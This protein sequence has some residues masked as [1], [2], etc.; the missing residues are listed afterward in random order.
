M[1]LSLE[2]CFQQERNLNMAFGQH[3]SFYLRD[4]WIERIFKNVSN[5][6]RFF[7]RKDAFEKVGLGKNMVKSLRFWALATNLVDERIREDRKKGHFITDFSK[8]VRDNDPYIQ[9]RDTLSLL[10]YYIVSRTEP[11][12]TWYWFFNIYNETFTTKNRISED[13]IEWVDIEKDIKVS[14][15]SL[16]RDVDCLIKLYTAG[17]NSQDPEEVNQSPLHVLNL[18]EVSQNSVRKVFKEGKDIGYTTLMYV[19]LDYAQTNQTKDL[20]V[21]EILNQPG[22]WGRVFN[23]SRSSVVDS[24]NRLTDHPKHSI[25]FIRTNNLDTVRL[26]DITPLEFLQFEYERKAEVAL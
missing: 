7:Y 3:Q 15:N 9:M 23:M 8:F 2:L 17:Q 25:S 19:L 5:D 24:L 22:L 10:H 1:I 16:K 12:T 26:P 18:L 21:D 11:A 4:R 6:D 13:L 14:E 20:L